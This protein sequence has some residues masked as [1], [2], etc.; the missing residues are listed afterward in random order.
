LYQVESLFAGTYANENPD[1]LGVFQRF[2]ECVKSTGIEITN[3]NIK[4]SCVFNKYAE[5][6]PEGA[7]TFVGNECGVC[8]DYALHGTS[9]INHAR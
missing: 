9:Y 1:F 8:R 6:I 4:E 3:Q 7:L 5:P 2:I